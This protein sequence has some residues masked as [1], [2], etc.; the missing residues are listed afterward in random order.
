MSLF[1]RF[2]HAVRVE[3]R[4]R[5]LDNLKRA[6]VQR[7]ERAEAHRSN[8][9]AASRMFNAQRGF[10]LIEL[11]IVVAIVA[12]LAA[13]AIPAYLNYTVRAKVSEGIQM[14]DGAQAAVATAYQA[15]MTPPGNNGE[16]GW[17][18]A[19][20]KYVSGLNVDGAGSVDIT[21]GNE[22]PAAIAGDTLSITPYLT[23]DGTSIG[24]L[25]GYAPVPTGWV[26]LTP[27][28]KG[29][30]NPST[31]TTVPAQYLPTNCTT[32]GG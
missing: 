20:G 21:F 17:T 22:A 18:S 5:R 6:Y 10:T 4:V 9:I 29:T 2:A 3:L 7:R 23:A 27:D 13:L 12:I 16:A 30:G 31:G 1:Q 14:A 11:M 15:N 8:V 19:Q 32:A 28:A 24:W 25:C 26:A